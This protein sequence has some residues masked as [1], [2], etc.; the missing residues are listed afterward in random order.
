MNVSERLRGSPPLCWRNT[1]MDLASI[2]SMRMR[3]VHIYG[4]V[5]RTMTIRRAAIRSECIRLI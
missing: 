3:S 2:I 1:E 4:C 5:I